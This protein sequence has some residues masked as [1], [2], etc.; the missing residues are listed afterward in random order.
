MSVRPARNSGSRE[1]RDEQVAVG[2]HAV[3]LGPAQGARAGGG[4]PRPGWRR[5]RSPWPASGR[6]AVPTTEPSATPASTRTPGGVGD[7]E[8]VQRAAGGQEP[9]GDVL[10]VEPHL[11]RVPVDRARRATSAGSGSPS[12]TRSCSAHEVEAGD[13]L[14]DRVL[15]LQPGVHLEEAERAVGVEDELDGAGADVAD[16]PCPRRPRR[17]PARR[18]ARRRRPA[19]APPRRSSGAPLDR[20]L[21]LEQ[22]RRRCRARRRRS[23][24]RRGAG[25]RR[26]ARGTRCRRRTRSAASR[27]APS[28][29]SASSAA[30]C[31]DPHAAPAAAERRLHQHREADLVGRARRASSVAGSAT[32]DARAAPAPRPPPS[33]R[34]ASIF[35]PI[36]VD[37]LGRRADERQPGVGARRGRSRRS[38]RGSRSRGG[39][40]RRRWRGRPRSTRSPRR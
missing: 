34:L 2:R 12:A 13:Q 20:A 25:R 30:S 22:V 4:R 5:A 19:T 8:A 7:A 38:P 32:V 31:D 39:R 21:A 29:A 36:G 1:D 33:A 3:D 23:A 14:G 18:A 27:R 9:G 16:A 35:E 11:D 40:R 24:P 17:R 37:R 10:G 28:T 6:S 15:D 26:T